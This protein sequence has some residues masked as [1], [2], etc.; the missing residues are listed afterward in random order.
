MTHARGTGALNS[1]ERGIICVV[2]ESLPHDIGALHALVMARTVERDA[3]RAECERLK[4]ILHKFAHAQF[5]ASSEQ[6]IAEQQSLALEH[7]KAAAGDNGAQ[8]EKRETR[9]DA[10]ERK[11][12]SNRGSLPAHLPRVHETIEPEDTSCPCCRTPMHKIGEDESQRLDVVPAQLRVLV[13]HRPKY[14]CRA[15]AGTVVQSPAPER[16]I[17]AGLPTE[18]LVAFVLVAKYFLH[19]PLYR[20]A[21][22]FALQGVRLDRSTLTFWV[23]YAARELMPIYTRLKEILLTSSKI[24]VDETRAPVLDPGRGRT[25]TGYFW[26]IARDD[27]AWGGADPPGA[28]F[29]YAP[30][31]GAK[32]AINLLD[33]FAGV[34]QCD[35]YAAYK[36]LVSPARSKDTA[37][38]ITLAF[39]W[40]HWRRRFVEIERKG[41]APIAQEALRRIAAIYAIEKTVRGQ[42]ADERRR[43]RREYSKPLV[44]AFKP[45][46]EEQLRAASAKSAIAEA[47]RYGLN[48]W[49]GLGRFLD[50]GRIELDTNN[51]ENAIRPI[52]LNR[53]NS[54]FAG[55]DFGAENWSCIASLIETCRRNEVDSQA[56]LTDVLTR[57]VH[58]WPQNRID[59][60]IPWTW[61]NNLAPRIAA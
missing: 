31:R 60:L 24:C 33:G 20:Q 43:V 32:H 7:I 47:I 41:P 23:S 44:D 54:L 8:D 14:A 10:P 13:T 45:W 53:K 48:H 35:G 21:Q 39:C 28:A 36:T 3:A 29:T 25:K 6:H 18:A 37:N 9:N 61:A 42:S 58:G 30:G 19:L 15:C 12:N 17:K 4:F 26:A 56:Y 50:D 34:V 22:M 59:E 49:V 38:A 51:V 2:L 57:L 1:I 27:R 55:H 5:G 52:A 16:L 46:L 11:R 40:S